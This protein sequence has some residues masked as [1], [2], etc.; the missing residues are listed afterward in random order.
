M[1]R[2]FFLKKENILI[3]ICWLLANRN[4]FSNR[5][6]TNGVGSLITMMETI[7]SANTV[8][9]TAAQLNELIIRL[10]IVEPN[11]EITQDNNLGPEYTKGRV[12][13]FNNRK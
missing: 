10:V 3:C 9:F 8:I 12:I 6:A 7:L 2:F 4:G 1:N 13:N 11:N 5:P